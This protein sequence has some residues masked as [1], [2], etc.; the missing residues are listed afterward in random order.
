VAYPKKDPAKQSVNAGVSLPSDVK[1][2]VTA[3]AEAQNK[4]LSRYVYELVLK[5]LEKA[6]AA[7]DREA[8]ANAT[9]VNTSVKK[10]R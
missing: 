1:R 10:R 6:D 8:K 5:Q 4:S 7:L 9:K 3:L 2:R